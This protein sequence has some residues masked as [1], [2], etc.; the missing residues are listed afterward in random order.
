MDLKGHVPKREQHTPFIFVPFNSIERRWVLRQ[1]VGCHLLNLL[2]DPMIRIRFAAKSE[3][4]TLPEAFEH[5]TL[6]RVES[7]P[8]LR[9]HQRHSW[10][11]FAVQLAALALA[12]DGRHAPPERAS[13]WMELLRKLTP[14]FPDDEPWRLIV[15]DSSK[16]AFMQPPALGGSL[17]KASPAGVETPD[18]LD[19]LITSKNH[20]IKSTVA[21]VAEA[22]D[23]LFA[24]ICKQT[25]EGFTG[26]G[27]YGISRMNGGM[28]NRVAF[29]LAPLDRK[30]GAHFKRD[31]DA[32]MESMSEIMNG[33]GNPDGIAL[34]WM[35]P[36]DGTASEALVLSDLHPL[37]IE[38]CRRIRLASTGRDQ[39]HATR[40]PTKAPRMQIKLLKGMVGDPW[41]P[42]DQTRGGVPLTLGPGGF[43][44]RRITEYLTTTERWHPSLLLRPTKREMASGKTMRLVARAMVRGQGK[45]E[46]YFDRSIP[47]RKGIYSGIGP[48]PRSSELGEISKQRIENVGSVQRVLSHAIQVYCAGGN[49]ENLKPEYR[50]LARP[51][52]TRLDQAIDA[53]FIEQLQVEFEAAPNARA[54]IREHWLRNGVDGVIDHAASIL[55]QAL[56]SLPCPKF[57]QY[58]AHTNAERLFWGRINSRKELSLSDVPSQERTHREIG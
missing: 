51:W 5:L 14:G 39:I 13:D 32:I 7:F 48:G 40:L 26:A 16:P 47:L 53:R 15:E 58:Q 9:P 8:A 49:S 27:N 55:N 20:D 23:W 35:I 41:T 21:K 45:T 44:F 31:L 38:V 17:T 30:P 11:A 18:E 36:W 42:Y 34:M 50:S 52:L 10:H 22:D 57:R 56:G 6:N 43:N 37:Y 29:S 19:V 2:S 33:L 54:G 4:V 24:L 25:M 3:R 1:I 46:G 12:A 28:G